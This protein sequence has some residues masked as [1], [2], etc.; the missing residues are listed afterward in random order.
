MKTLIAL[1][2]LALSSTAAQADWED[3]FQNPDLSVNY[4]GHV[5]DVRL[6]ADDPV[7]AAFPGNGDL[8]SGESVEGGIGSSYNVL[9]SL[10]QLVKGNPDFEV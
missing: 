4:K 6:A 7:A 2:F 5:E 9:T 3:V 1:S 10:E 8:H